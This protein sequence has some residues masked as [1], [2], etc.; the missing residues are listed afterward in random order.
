MR[1][2]WIRFKD[3]N[4]RITVSGVNAFRIEE[5]DRPH[6]R[7][8]PFAWL[9]L[10][11]PICGMVIFCGETDQAEREYNRQKREEP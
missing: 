1:N 7:L 9:W 10:I 11:I 6:C 8:V 2:L 4:Y 3:L 5:K